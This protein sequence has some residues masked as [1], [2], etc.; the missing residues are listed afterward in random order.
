MAKDMV[1]S[2]VVALSMNDEAYIDGE[3]S[4][5]INRD[6]RHAWLVA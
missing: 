5:M 2:S 1:D 4:L 3:E 6:D